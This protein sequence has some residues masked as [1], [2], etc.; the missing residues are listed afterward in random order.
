MKKVIFIT[1][2]L[3]EL[4]NMGDCS[5]FEKQ[6][7]GKSFENALLLGRIKLKIQRLGW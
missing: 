7:R 1:E 6:V 4:E 2:I 3:E 5:R